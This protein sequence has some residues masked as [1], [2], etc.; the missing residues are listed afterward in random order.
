MK[1]TLRVV[2]LASSIIGVFWGS[3]ALTTSLQTD[4]A[5]FSSIPEAAGFFFLG[6]AG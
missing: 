3:F 6:A 4:D 5:Q 2:S 1:T